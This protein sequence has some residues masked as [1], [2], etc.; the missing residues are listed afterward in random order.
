MLAGKDEDEMKVGV[1]HDLIEDTNWTIEHFCRSA[2]LSESQIEA[3]IALTRNDQESYNDY[4][5][6]VQQNDLARR[7]KLNDLE[8]NYSRCHELEEPER[9]TLGTRY[10]NAMIILRNE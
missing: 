10:L 7:V 1:C 9:T 8:D 4:I 6:R 2:P 5:M 3:V